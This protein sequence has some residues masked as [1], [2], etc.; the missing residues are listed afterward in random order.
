MRVRA[1][2]QEAVLTLSQKDLID[3]VLKGIVYARKNG[4]D[5]L[6]QTAQPREA[7]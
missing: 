7:A 2:G 5:Y 6:V 4:V 1:C 3:L